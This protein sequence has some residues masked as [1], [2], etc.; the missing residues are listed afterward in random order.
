M[1]GRRM[2]IEIADL[3]H[4]TAAQSIAA[5]SSSDHEELGGGR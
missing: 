5:Q 1:N 3:C 2:V 4:S